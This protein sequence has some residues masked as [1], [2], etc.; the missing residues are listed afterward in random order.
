M[1]ADKGYDSDDLRKAIRKA[2]AKP[3]IPSRKGIRKRRHNKT[4]YKVRNQVERFFNR[5]KHYR[6]LATRYDKTDTSY[7]GFLTLATVLL[8]LN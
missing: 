4:L 8:N 6:R 3:V 5:L 2:G 1:V 7:N